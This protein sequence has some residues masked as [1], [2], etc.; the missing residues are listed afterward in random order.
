[1]SIAT[2]LVEPTDANLIKTLRSRVISTVEGDDNFQDELH[3]IVDA[4]FS[5]GSKRADTDVV[6]AFETLTDDTPSIPPRVKG[7]GQ[8]I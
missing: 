7:R 2:P 6:F 4:G 3:C 1:M 8:A 5:A